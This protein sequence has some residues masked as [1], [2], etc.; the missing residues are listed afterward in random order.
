MS[1]FFQLPE[2]FWV[3]LSQ[4]IAI[5][6]VLSGDNA[7]VIALAANSLPPK[8]QR[9]AV[10]WGAGAAVGM[11]IVLASLALAL[12]TLPYLKIIGAAL[13][14]WIGVKLLLPEN[15]EK[16]IQSGHNLWAAI[17]TIMLA[18][19]VM[20][21]DNV[22]AIAGAAKGN[23]LLIAIGLLVSIPIVIF[24]STLLLALMKKFPVIITAGAALLGY[25]AGEMVLSD[26][27][28]TGWISDRAPISEHGALMVGA[29]ATVGVKPWMAAHLP[30]LHKATAIAGAAT[31][32]L[33]GKFLAR[34]KLAETPEPEQA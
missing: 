18:D 24:G 19:A 2:H 29:V 15:D 30:M 9:M 3:A 1:E 34:K 33:I 17:R 23:I 7:V 27:A 21:L 11:R 26:P 20:S 5:D 10:F 8:Q 14:L 4:I 32:V 13:L 16:D 28:V 25:I 12:L 31:V 22:I 6:M